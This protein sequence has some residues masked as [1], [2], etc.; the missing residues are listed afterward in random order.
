MRA[1]C[2][3]CG[4]LW[5]LRTD[6]P[7]GAECENCGGA[8]RLPPPPRMI[9]GEPVPPPVSSAAERRRLM[10]ELLGGGG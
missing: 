9:N 1:Y 2:E 6:P 3:E 8:L 4:M 7:A 5:P 10:D